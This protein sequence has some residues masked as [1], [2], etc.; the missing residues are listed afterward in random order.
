MLADLDRYLIYF[1]LVFLHLYDLHQFCL[2]L[3]VVAL[4]IEI[5]VT[6]GLFVFLGLRYDVEALLDSLDICLF[7]Q[8]QFLGIELAEFLLIL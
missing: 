6:L 8:F 3:V 2:F 5:E 4:E 1:L 7:M